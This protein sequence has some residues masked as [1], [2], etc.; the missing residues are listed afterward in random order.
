MG[1][2][3]PDSLLL[4]NKTFKQMLDRCLTV[5]NARLHDDL[6][7]CRGELVVIDRLD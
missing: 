1:A 5:M 3:T 7:K 4:G 2:Q 6:A